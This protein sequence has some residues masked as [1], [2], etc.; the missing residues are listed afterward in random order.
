M[1]QYLM[2]QSN[3]AS[4]CPNHGAVFREKSKFLCN[5]KKEY[6]ESS[7]FGHEDAGKDVLV[8]YDNIPSDQQEIL[9]EIKNFCHDFMNELFEKLGV[10]T[11]NMVEKI[12]EEIVKKVKTI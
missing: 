10:W 12:A 7:P 11:R 1:T 9:R 8:H 3:K 6:A 2:L 4:L 5:S